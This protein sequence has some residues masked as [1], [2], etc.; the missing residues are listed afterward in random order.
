[1]AYPAQA[2]LGIGLIGLGRHGTRYLTHLLQNCP[3]ARLAAVCRKRIDE[4]PQDVPAAV[5]LYGSYHELIADPAVQAVIVVTPPSLCHD[6]CLDAVKAGKP[7]LIEKPLATTGEEARA[8]VAA[9]DR[10]GILL[11]TAHTMRFDR[12]IL[13]AKEQL[14]KI[15]PLRYATLT[16]RIEYK[17]SAPALAQPGQRGTL[18]ETG[19]HL[20]DLVRFFSG[21][22]VAEVRCEVDP[23]PSVAPETMALGYVRTQGGIRCVIDVARVMSGRVGRAEWIGVDGQI[24]VDWVQRTVK[25]QLGNGPAEEWTVPQEPTVLAV[26]TSFLRSIETG[27]APPVTGADGCRAVEIA[28]A[29]YESA[30]LDGA[31]VPVYRRPH[32]V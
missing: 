32:R 7:L 17:A 10:A 16:S 22:E 23:P 15:G 20:L 26:L 8:M 14:S 6:I 13:H 11:M 19:I 1:M 12:A 27:H 28:D 30:A 4:R 31:A 2:S 21:Q 3:T 9:A 5:S 25:L 18:L 24:A 29:C